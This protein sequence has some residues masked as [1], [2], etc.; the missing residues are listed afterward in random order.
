[1]VAREERKKTFYVFI[2]PFL[3]GMSFTFGWG[4]FFYLNHFC[5]NFPFWNWFLRFFGGFENI[6]QWSQAQYKEHETY[7]HLISC[8]FDQEFK[9]GSI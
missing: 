9:N 2:F 3:L 5:R 4:R 7:A 8:Q 6:R 1:M